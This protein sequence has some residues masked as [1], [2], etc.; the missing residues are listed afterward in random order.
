[1]LHLGKDRLCD[2]FLGVCSDLCLADK[3][4]LERRK[5][6]LGLSYCVAHL[7][8]HVAYF[9]KGLPRGFDGAE[10]QLFADLVCTAFDHRDT[11]IGTS[12]DDFKR[13]FFNLVIGRIDDVRTVDMAYPDS[14]D[15]PTEWNITDVDAGARSVDREDVGRI[16][17][18][19]RNHGR[20]HLDLPSKSLVE[21][22]AHRPVYKPG[23]KN[24]TI[25]RAGFPL[26]EATGNLA[27]GVILLVIFYGKRYEVEAFGSFG[28]T[29]NCGKHS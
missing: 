29:A 18:V 24:L 27:R 28:S 25:L 26:D 1:V 15:R 4:D 16:Y 3:F 7:A 13:R 22:G 2:Q 11:G 23:N 19:C 8:Y 9:R 12:Y 6:K 10:H 21:Q 20:H 17:Q 14:G 5:R